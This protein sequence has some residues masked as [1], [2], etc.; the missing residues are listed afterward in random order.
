MRKAIFLLALLFIVTLF[1]A[2]CK[3]GSV[4]TEEEVLKG[5]PVVEMTT[6]MGVMKIELYSDV[7]PKHAWNFVKLTQDG[8]YNGLIFHRIIK[9]FMI[10]GG[11]PDGTGM[12]GPG[13][14]VPAEFSDKKHINGTLAAARKGGPANPKKESSGS[15]FYICHGSPSHL[16][17]EYTIY[18]Q[19]I[20]GLEVVDKIATT[21]TG[22]RDKPA[23]DVIIESIKVVDIV[24]H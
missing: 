2:G 22:A 13:Y 12:G 7:A 19:V 21:K 3:E 17:G 8:F 14:T 23:E 11:D 9:N 6:S 1:S 20:E 16:D 5:N 15:Q 24:K 18:G 10:Q 4:L